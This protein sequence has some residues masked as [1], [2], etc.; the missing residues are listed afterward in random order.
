M[1]IAAEHLTQLFDSD[2]PDPQLVVEAGEA[3]VVSGSAGEQQG[4]VVAS[5]ADLLEESGGRAPSGEALDQLAAR[6]DSAVT[7]MGG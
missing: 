4:L 7:S 5:R 2:L 3:R 6:L 1:T